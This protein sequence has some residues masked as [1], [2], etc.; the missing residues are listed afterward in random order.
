[1]PPS[2]W[3]GSLIADVPRPSDLGD[4]S[5][6][7]ECALV[8]ALEAGLAALTDG[9]PISALSGTAEPVG[10]FDPASSTSSAAQWS[11]NRKV[12]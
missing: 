11:W 6:P 2:P 8:N 10:T 4:S 1:M 12:E 3:I 7:A 5:A 9:D